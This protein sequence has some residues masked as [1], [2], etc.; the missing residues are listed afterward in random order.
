[1]GTCWFYLN[2]L[3]ELL[4]FWTL[5]EALLCSTRFL[6]ISL[7]V[8]NCF[9]YHSFH[10]PLI[11]HLN[12]NFWQAFLLFMNIEKYYITHLKWAY[13]VQ[14]P[15]GNRKPGTGKNKSLK[16]DEEIHHEIRCKNRTQKCDSFIPMNVMTGNIILLKTLMIIHLKLEFKLLHIFS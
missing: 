4:E 3:S 9:G 7:F 2:S 6:F 11:I 1:M 16:T 14:L 12:R 5:V 10:F 8:D 15:V 13:W